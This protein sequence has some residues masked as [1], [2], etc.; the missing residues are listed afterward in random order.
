[1]VAVTIS[2]ADPERP[3]AVGNSVQRVCPA[4]PV[5]S[6]PAWNVDG[7]HAYQRLWNELAADPDAPVL[8]RYLG[9]PIGSAAARSTFMI[10]SSRGR[11]APR[12]LG[13]R[14]GSYRQVETPH[15]QLFSHADEQ[16]TR[17]I[18]TDLEHVYWVWTQ[19]FF[20]LWDGS[21]Q[22][23]LHLQDVAAD[24]SVASALAN[25]RARMS[26][27]RKLRIVLLKDADDYARTLGQSTPGIEQSTGFYSDERQTS[28]FYPSTSADAVASRRHELIH[29]LF[30]EATRSRLTGELPGA[31]SDF[32]LIEGIAGYFESLHRDRC[33]ATVGGWDS[34]RL[35]FARYRVLGGRDLIPFQEMRADGHASAQQRSDLARWYANAIAY[36]HGF[37]DGDSVA[38]R[39]WIYQQ[40]A[41][42][43]E[44]PID[45]PSS[46]SVESPAPSPAPSPERT[47]V[48]FLKVDDHQLRSNPTTRPLTQ[49]CLSGCE[50]SP[51]G[52]ASLSA[53]S[54][55]TWIDLSR[56][57]IA[58]DELTRL[59]PTPVRLDQLSLEATQVDDSIAPWL[60]Q[61]AGLREL[62]L[63]W[64]RCGDPTI[65]SLAGHTN[66]KTLWLTGS[67]VTD[68]AI[69]TL[70]S[71]SSLESIDVQRT[72]ITSDGLARLKTLRPDC[73]VNPLQLRVQ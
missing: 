71:I 30:R 14:S 43:Y 66:L 35:Q 9:L 28:F 31:R 16:T 41:A 50:T 44:I 29:Q 11:S 69:A 52:L 68:A 32:W 17:E 45:I 37:L 49:L 54:D 55:W 18:A 23:A 62:D 6:L 42:L 7:W 25:S 60:G 1:M 63:S 13:W 40:L 24:Q 51:D 56:Q 8:R 36:T 67:G 48:D 5:E 19:L 65:A 20:P 10:K 26:S 61:A 33:R 3:P 72:Q 53:T 64:T 70:A 73:N 47:L 39:R 12:W 38:N 59:C 34:P 27:R 15:L 57:P 21:Q 46:G 4:S 58:T 22:V 2:T